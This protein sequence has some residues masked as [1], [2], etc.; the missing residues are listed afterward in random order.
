[1]CL[2]CAID[3]CI[4]LLFDT[5]CCRCCRSILPALLRLL[6]HP[7]EDRRASAAE[8]LGLLC[9]L[10]PHVVASALLLAVPPAVTND[11]LSILLM[12]LSGDDS[13][14]TRSH[15][16]A[17]ITMCAAT[18]DA[19]ALKKISDCGAVP[20]LLKL[21]KEAKS[22][23]QKLRAVSCLEVRCLCHMS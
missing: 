15:Y 16:A 19:T 5:L 3:C 12:R 22:D 4:V 21:L 1:M 23:D 14:E 9:H 2:L 18:H 10:A 6:Q 17:L 13:P 7:S 20:Y 8:S 11:A